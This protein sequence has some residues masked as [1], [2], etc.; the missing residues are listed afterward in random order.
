MRTAGVA[1]G[2]ALVGLVLVGDWLM[3]QESNL[4]MAFVCLPLVIWVASSSPA[5]IATVTL[6]LAVMALAGMLYT[7]GTPAPI[8]RSAE[9]SCCGPSCNCKPFWESRR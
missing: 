5:R 6:L 4:P 2:I 1:L 9:R 8:P 7:H 3:P